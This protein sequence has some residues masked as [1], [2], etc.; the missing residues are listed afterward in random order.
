MVLKLKLGLRFQGSI[1]IKLKE[2]LNKPFPVPKEDSHRSSASSAC[3]QHDGVRRRSLGSSSHG[4]LRL[5]AAGFPEESIPVRVGFPLKER[6]HRGLS[7][8]VLCTKPDGRKRKNCGG[9]NRTTTSDSSLSGAIQDV[10][11]SVI[12]DQSV[13]KGYVVIFSRKE[14]S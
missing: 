7:W 4:G 13:H 8:P 11:A 2:G 1:Y 9:R 12:P 3:G 10:S 5:R 14:E 6:R